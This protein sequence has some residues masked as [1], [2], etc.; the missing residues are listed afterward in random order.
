MA[1]I[2]LVSCTSK[3]QLGK[4]K[5][6]DL[7][8]K[9]RWFEKARPL[10]EYYDKWF[11]ISAEHYLVDPEEE[12]GFYKKTLKEMKKPE[13]I[14]WAE[15][16]LSSLL[17]CLTKGDTITIYAGNTYREFIEPKLKEI[18]FQVTVP[19]KGISGLEIQRKKLEEALEWC[20]KH[21][22]T[23]DLWKKIADSR[24]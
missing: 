8:M 17:P 4:H 6:C 13:R 23:F 19:L 11:I 22:F 2:C 21:G 15:K 12:I 9:S 16:V 5:A 3:K 7:Y 24:I 14:Q 1:N 20:Q 10:A 18:R